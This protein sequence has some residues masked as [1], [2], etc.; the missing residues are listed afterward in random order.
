MMKNRYGIQHVSFRNLLP[1]RE[2]SYTV[3]MHNEKP[4]MDQLKAVEEFIVEMKKKLFGDNGDL[5]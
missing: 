5:L 4:N 1:G 2:N 3:L